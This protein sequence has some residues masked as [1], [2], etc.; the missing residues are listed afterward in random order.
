MRMAASATHAGYT[1]ILHIHDRYVRIGLR[2]SIFIVVC[3][4]HSPA[5]TATHTHIFRYN[6][7]RSSPWWAHTCWD[8]DR[9]EDDPAPAGEDAAATADE[10]PL[11]SFASEEEAF[12]AEEKNADVEEERELAR[13]EK[14][15]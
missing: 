7:G 4:G 3:T 5:E 11:V 12:V 8:G 6:H 15:D 13:E 14:M 1:I 9:S 2:E 10:G